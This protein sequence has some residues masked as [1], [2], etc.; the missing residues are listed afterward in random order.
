MAMSDIEPGPAQI[1]GQPIGNGRL[2]CGAGH[3]RRIHRVD[4]DEM[5]G[6]LEGIH[7]TDSFGLRRRS[8]RR[9][10]NLYELPVLGQARL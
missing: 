10:G 1:G 3:Q 5:L 9:L 7:D 4:R 8:I 2:A 6:E